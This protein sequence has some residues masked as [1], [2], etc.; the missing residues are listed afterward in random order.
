VSEWRE[1]ALCAQVDPHIFFPDKG[2]TASQAKRV[3]L[4]CEVTEE[5]RADSKDERFGVWGGQSERDRK[6]K[7]RRG[8]RS[9]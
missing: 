2:E 9:V 7:R 3:C 1:L 5:C 4:Q 8:R 6:A